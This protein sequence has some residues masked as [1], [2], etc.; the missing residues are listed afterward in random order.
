MQINDQISL[1]PLQ[2]F[3]DF[4][5]RRAFFNHFS[6]VDKCYAPYIRLTNDKEIKKAQQRDIL[7]E[8]NTRMEVMPQLMVNNISDFLL[9]ADY[10][11]S[12]EYKEINWNMGCP[13]PMVAKRNL[14]AGMLNN[15]EDIDRLLDQVFTQS[16]IKLG[17][18]MRM[19]YESTE[20]ILKVIPILNKY[21]ITEL[22]I[23]A[24]FAKQL[25]KPSVDLNRFEECIAI[26][27]TPLTY[28]G[29]INSFDDFTRL[30]SR[31][32]QVTNWMIG[33]GVVSDPFLPE[34]IKNHNPDYPTDRWQT[35]EAFHDDLFQDYASVLQGDRQI[36]LK[37]LSFWE[38]FSQAFPNPHKTFKRI[39]KAK[40]LAAFEEA[41]KENLK[42]AVNE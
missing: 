19:G 41:V 18:K 27:K 30:K 20:E 7:R 28:N 40:S 2:S 26:S 25:Y 12:L 11:Q 39:K 38:Y 17:L 21:P 24:R 6:G 31:F 4:R 23:H 22:I 33:R 14:G 9:V 5:F 1:A 10:V 36:V 15:P 32:P 3:T 37:M 16:T 29:D 8:N 35:F 42:I 34:Q 13:Y